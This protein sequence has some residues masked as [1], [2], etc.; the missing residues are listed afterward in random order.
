MSNLTRCLYCGLLQDEPKGVKTC[1]RCGGE[2]A[3][4]PAPLPRTYLRATMELDQINAPADQVIDRHL[5]VTINT[6]EEVPQG[7]RA[8]TSTGREPMGF[9]AVLDASGSMRG[10]KMESAKEAIRQA[11]RRLH[12]GDT[13]S[14][15][16]FANKVD[17]V[18]ERRMTDD[19][20][21]V[22][23]SAIDAPLFLTSAKTGEHV[24]SMFQQL[25]E[26]VA[27]G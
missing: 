6:P 22:V 9:H 4:E 26:L 7:E 13:F 10:P 23:S 5:V 3:F 16:T 15:V 27:A 2:L 21:S 24:A 14:L 1:S 18:E 11:I 20:L 8:P 17:L 25:G 12:D 19:E